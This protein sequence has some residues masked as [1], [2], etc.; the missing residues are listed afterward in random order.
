MFAAYLEAAGFLVL[1][2]PD[3]H[4]VVNAAADSDVHAAIVRVTPRRDRRNELDVATALKQRQPD[5]PIVLLTSD[6][7]DLTH[8]ASDH[9]VM[10]PALPRALAAAIHGAVA[11]SVA[12]R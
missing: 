9:V 12:S 10:L 6:P 8:A 7:A 11:R 3:V 1:S 5:L 4:G 2:F